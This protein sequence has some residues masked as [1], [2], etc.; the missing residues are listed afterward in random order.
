M[1]FYEKKIDEYKNAV[2]NSSQYLIDLIIVFI[3]QTI[4]LPI[5]FLYILYVLFRK[6]V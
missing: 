6:I 1:S 3:F 4:F 5:V 2:D